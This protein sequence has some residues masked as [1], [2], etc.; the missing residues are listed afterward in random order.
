MIKKKEVR[1]KEI[2]RI[3]KIFYLAAILLLVLL[4]YIFSI[5]ALFN[6][7]I[8]SRSTISYYNL[9][10]SEILFPKNITENNI[11]KYFFELTVK[12]DGKGKNL[13]VF[14]VVPERIKTASQLLN[15]IPY[16]GAVSYFDENKK[17]S[18][19][20][21]AAFG[22]IGKNFRIIPDTIYEISITRNVNWTLPLE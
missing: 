21:I 9:N 13:I 8:L 22:G 17:K 6:T 19:G 5:K 14:P 3:K 2:K 16:C 7:T 4:V 18:V 11:T 10:E 15:L 20:F 12:P 1:K